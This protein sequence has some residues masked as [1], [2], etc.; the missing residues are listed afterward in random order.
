MGWSVFG[1]VHEVKVSKT[2][3]GRAT[4]QFLLLPDLFTEFDAADQDS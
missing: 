1:S 4:A 2:S 3:H